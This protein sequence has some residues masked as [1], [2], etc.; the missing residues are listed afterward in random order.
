MPEVRTYINM[1]ILKGRIMG[2]IEKR[3]GVNTRWGIPT[4]C[5][6]AVNNHKAKPL[7]SSN[8]IVMR[9]TVCR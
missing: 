9:R 4:W 2:W 1:T 7:S 8:L 5:S 3:C 6:V